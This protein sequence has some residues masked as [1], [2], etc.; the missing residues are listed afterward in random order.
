[1]DAEK[2]KAEIARQQAM[3]Q[4]LAKRYAKDVSCRRCP[5]RMSVCNQ[6]KRRTVCSA[7][8]IEAAELAVSKAGGGDGC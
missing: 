4:W 7:L 6:Q 8:I 3:L 1:M 5:A 2:L